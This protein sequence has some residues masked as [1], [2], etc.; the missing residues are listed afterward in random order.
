MWLAEAGL[1][2][3]KAR[4]YHPELGRFLQAD[5]IG[6]GD[7]LNLYAYVGNDPVNTVDP[8]G[9]A[10]EDKIVVTAVR[11]AWRLYLELWGS[12]ASGSGFGRGGGAGG[13]G[14]GGGGGGASDG[15][16][17]GD[18]SS[19]C[20]QSLIDLGNMFARASNDFS[21][22]STAILGTGVA[23][24]AIGVIAA[25]GTIIAA[26]PVILALGGA[27]GIVAGG[28]QI[29]A[30]LL[31]GRGGAGYGNAMKGALGLGA[32]AVGSKLFGFR[33]P[34]GYRTVSQRTSDF[35]SKF[36]SSILGGVYDLT[37][38]IPDLTATTEQ[39]KQ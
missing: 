8:T 13:G 23:V 12:S 25:S 27:V 4:A 38:Q 17:A 26:A 30:G 37:Q 24:G 14:G 20:N 11:S 36:A 21:F 6:Y 16:G 7:G 19:N 29:T 35:G 28:S 31:Q 9:R 32:G 3:Y 2:H 18:N 10:W 33:A 1:Y 22:V 15:D 39:C 34:S 5:P